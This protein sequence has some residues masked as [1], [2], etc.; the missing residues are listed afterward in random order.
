VRTVGVG[1]LMGPVAWLAVSVAVSYYMQMRL[2]IAVPDTI[3]PS[4]LAGGFGWA[5]LGLLLSAAHRWRERAAIR[6]GIAGEAPVDGRRT[7]L[8]GTLEPLG[9]TLRAPLDGAECL[10]YTYDISETR[11]SGKRRSTVTHFKGVGLA[12]SMIV[13]RTGSYKLLVVPDL[14]ADAPHASV[15]EMIAA[16]RRHAH[17]TTFSGP[18]TSAQELIDRW[19]DAD[20]A[21]RSDVAYATLDEVDFPRCQFAQQSVRRG[22]SVCVFGPYSAQQGGIVPSSTSPVRLIR[23]NIEQVASSL[24]SKAI[25]RVVL[26][27]LFGAV[28]AAVIRLASA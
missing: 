6:G 23:G 19:N 13:T 16:F 25:M 3:G 18:E 2:G 26:G 4:L 11:G 20:G 14:E 10:A 8:V 22:A 12:P 9:P 5:S 17:A 7:V 24:R 15:D 28:A 1:C 21:Y 27:L